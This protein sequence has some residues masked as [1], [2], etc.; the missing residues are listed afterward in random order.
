MDLLFITEALDFTWES[1]WT[2]HL[3]YTKAASGKY[4]YWI[5]NYIGIVPNLVNE[6]TVVPFSCWK[7]PNYWIFEIIVLH[8]IA[9][10]LKAQQSVPVN[11][12]NGKILWMTL[13]DKIQTYLTV[14]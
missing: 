8:L 11:F 9:M 5:H 3:G 12:G 14:L 1:H 2:S 10:S 4:I 6:S 13:R 7:I